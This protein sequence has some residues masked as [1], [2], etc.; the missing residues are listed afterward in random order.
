M[1]RFVAIGVDF[2]IIALI[3]ISLFSNAPLMK[4]EQATAAT[5]SAAGDRRPRAG[6]TV[7]ALSA[8]FTADPTATTAKPAPAAISAAPMARR[9]N[10]APAA[11]SRR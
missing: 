3:G 4:K 5:M 10:F 9:Q 7:A 1:N 6:R 8:G 2:A 11:A